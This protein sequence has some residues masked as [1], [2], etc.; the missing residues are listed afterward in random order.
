MEFGFFDPKKAQYVTK[1][2]EPIKINVLDPLPGSQQYVPKPQAVGTDSQSQQT[3]QA[4]IASEPRGLKLPGDTS[5]VSFQGLP[6]WRWI[7][8]LS[9]GA[10]GIFVLLVLRDVFS[11]AAKTASERSALRA[12]QEAKSWNRLKG[13][14]ARMPGGMP[15]SEVVSVYDAIAGQIF[16]AVDRIY[17]VGSRSYS[18]E[19]LKR[20]L[21]D[22]RGMP[23]AVWT[24]AAK[25]LEFS[26]LVRFASSAGAI[27]ESAARADGPKWVTEAEHV[28]RLIERHPREATVANS[29]SHSL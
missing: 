19:E 23:E 16:D 13:L 17:A 3:P 5:T 9:L 29:P 25:I 2:T 22:D 21:V 27:S 10:F 14:A 15:W 24:R 11:K 18:R 8:W 6:M 26:E 28:A 4:K 20:M 1:T 7:Y 12:K